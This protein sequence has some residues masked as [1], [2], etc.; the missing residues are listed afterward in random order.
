MWIIEVWC[1]IWMTE[2]RS[3]CANFS[4]LGFEGKIVAGCEL[5]VWS[6]GCNFCSGSSL[7]PCW[8]LASWWQLLWNLLCWLSHT[9]GAPEPAS[10]PTRL[11]SWILSIISTRR[12]FIMERDNPISKSHHFTVLNSYEICFALQ[13]H[14]LLCWG[15]EF[16]LF[17]THHTFTTLAALCFSSWF[18]QEGLPQTTRWL[19]CPLPWWCISPFHV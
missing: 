10:P 15:V 2:S 8:G 16:V 18:T 12:S 13:F 3:Q 1:R 17:P 14:H 5:L 7:T 4:A 11:I 19:V 9:T 6:L